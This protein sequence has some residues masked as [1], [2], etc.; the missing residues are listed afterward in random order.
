MLPC[1]SWTAMTLAI[2]TAGWDTVRYAEATR[3]DRACW[4]G[5]GKR[6]ILQQLLLTAWTQTSVLYNRAALTEETKTQCLQGGRGSQTF[7]EPAE[8][9]YSSGSVVN[10][11]FEISSY[12]QS[13][14]EVNLLPGTQKVPVTN[15]VLHYHIKSSHNNV[16]PKLI[17]LAELSISTSSVWGISWGISVFRGPL[18]ETFQ[19]SSPIS[20]PWACPN[21]TSDC[22]W[23]YSVS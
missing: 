2:P 14:R 8:G 7:F 22:C 21:V 12:C 17:V 10:S 16:L 9:I 5:K 20:E 1:Q 15:R 11:A 13:S 19:K 4:T 3:Q 23:P 18:Y 6:W